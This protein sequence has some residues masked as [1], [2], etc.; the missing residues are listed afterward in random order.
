MN[1]LNAPFLGTYL[2]VIA[3]K[4]EEGQWGGEQLTLN[5]PK[6]ETV[7]AFITP[8][9]VG[10]GERF[11]ILAIY[12]YYLRLET[13]EARLLRYYGEATAALGLVKEVV[14]AEALAA[15]REVA[16][17]RMRSVYPESESRPEDLR[18][19]LINLINVIGA[20]GTN[21]KTPQQLGVAQFDFETDGKFM[22]APLRVNFA[23]S[24]IARG[25]RRACNACCVACY[26]DQSP[27]MTIGDGEHELST[28][29]CKQIIDI[30]W[31]YGSIH[32][33]FTGGEFTTR[34]DCV[35]LIA[36]AKKYL[37][38]LNTNGWLLTRK[39]DDNSP[40]LIE[41]LRAADL[42]IIQITWYSL[43][44]EIHDVLMGSAGAYEKSLAGIQAAVASGVGVSINIPLCNLNGPHIVETLEHLQGLG[45]RFVTLSG[46]IPA[47][48]AVAMINSP[49]ALSHDELLSTV[50][51]AAKYGQAHGMRI[52][53]T[54]P[55]Q[56]S[57]E[58]LSAIGVENPRCDAAFLQVAIG[59]KGDVM[60]CQSM[61]AKDDSL[62]NLLKTPWAKIWNSAAMKKIRAKA[63][64]NHCP[65]QDRI[66]GGVK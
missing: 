65:L 59:P 58:E 16:V 41:E 22:R 61:V 66:D 7:R 28:E 19:S 46:L 57:D 60:G 42:D 64:T 35:E 47:G 51:A 23:F 14:S 54:S 40:T 4:M 21:R 3:R 52:D 10:V 62:G 8:P 34:P 15:A 2:R 31:M 32:A 1:L 44:K 56:L 25:Q 27:L 9:Q 38:F 49:Q 24:P 45:I 13:W 37:T 11:H 39:K 20:I 12:G 43:R 26:A 53:F 6:G 63:R 30:M 36:Y 18:K 29:E 48:G 33:V 55:G 17:E 50:T 5:F